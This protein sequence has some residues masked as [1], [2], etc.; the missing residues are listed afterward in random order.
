M[1]NREEELSRQEDEIKDR[2]REFNRIHEN[3]DDGSTQ[4]EWNLDLLAIKEAEIENAREALEVRA[5]E[6]SEMFA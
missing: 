2:I 1:C 3:L 4:T 6:I 5:K